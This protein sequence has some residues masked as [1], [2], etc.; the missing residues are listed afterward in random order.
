MAKIRTIKPEFWTSEQVMECS[1]QARLL[2]IG[3]WNFADDGGVHPAALK[4]LKAEVYPADD[5]TVQQVSGWISELIDNG[6]IT[7]FLANGKRWWHITGWHHQLINRPS[8]RYPRPP[9]QIDA[10][11]PLAADHIRPHCSQLIY[12]PLT[13]SVPSPECAGTVDARAN[14]TDGGK[15]SGV[16][17]AEANW[18]EE[19]RNC[20]DDSRQDTRIL[21]KSTATT[22]SE[23][24]RDIAATLPEHCHDIAA[25]PPEGKGY[26]RDKDKDDDD[27]EKIP[28]SVPSQ[29]FNAQIARK[30]NGSKSKETFFDASNMPEISAESAREFLTYRHELRA[31]MT[32]I[33][34][35]RMLTEFGKAGLTPDDGVALM[36]SRGW[37]GFEADWVANS[38]NTRRNNH[39]QLN[40]HDERMETAAQRNARI[41]DEIHAPHQ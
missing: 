23:H 5:C 28:I 34:W 20:M 35:R 27:P 15:P 14:S 17:P 30:K 37:R 10:P 16:D 25:T 39:A 1:P 19:T 22:L 24:G 2:F 13:P 7:E 41:W 11:L 31:P 38:H 12:A 29:N 26:G 18:S 40:L 8:I 9:A 32:T 3:M 21:A 4:T 36:M 33:A 6:L